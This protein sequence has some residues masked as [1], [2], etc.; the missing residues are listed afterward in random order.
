MKMLSGMTVRWLVD[1]AGK[2]FPEESFG[3]LS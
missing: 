1:L 3:E 2:G